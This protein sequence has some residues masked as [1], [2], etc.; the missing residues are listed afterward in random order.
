MKFN[1]TAGLSHQG[2]HQ[3]PDERLSEP[4]LVL[5]KED[6][7]AWLRLIREVQGWLNTRTSINLLAWAVAEAL[8]GYAEAARGAA[9]S[10]GKGTCPRGRPPQK[11]EPTPEAQGGSAMTGNP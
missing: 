10:Y 2:R 3:S 1:I 5:H 8:T 7:V 11:P 4:N 9:G 6:I